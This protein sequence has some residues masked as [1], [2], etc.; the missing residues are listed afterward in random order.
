VADLYPDSGL[1]PADP[2]GRAKARFFIDIVNTK[3]AY[4]YVGHLHGDGTPLVAILP[5]LQ[6]I[7]AMLPAD[8]TFALGDELTAADASVAPFLLHLPAFL[9]A[10]DTE[11]VGAALHSEKLARLSK[12]YQALKEH[13]SVIS[14]YDEVQFTH[15]EFVSLVDVCVFRHMYTRFLQISSGRSNRATEN[16]Y[17]ME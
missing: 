17:L 7:Q 10:R 6:A 11:G 8:K 16:Q 12:Y 15:S 3:F 14:T 13:P 9:N 2:V 5:G 4:P 1:L